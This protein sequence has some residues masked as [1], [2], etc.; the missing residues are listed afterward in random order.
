M[1]KGG[2]I[3]LCKLNLILAL[4]IISIGY[5]GDETTTAVDADSSNQYSDCNDSLCDSDHLDLCCTRIVCE[6]QGGYWYNE[7][8]YESPYTKIAA[9]NQFEHFRQA[10]DPQMNNLIPRTMTIGNHCLVE[11]EDWIY[12]IDSKGNQIFRPSGNYS[13]LEESMTTP[14][15]GDPQEWF[16]NSDNFHQNISKTVELFHQL[17]DVSDFLPPQAIVKNE[18]ILLCEMGN[19]N[20]NAYLGRSLIR[21][22]EPQGPLYFQTIF[23]GTSNPIRIDTNIWTN[24]IDELVNLLSDSLQQ[25]HPQIDNE[26]LSIGTFF[27]PDE[28]RFEITAYSYE[29]EEFMNM[30]ESSNPFD[31]DYFD[32][33]YPHLVDVALYRQS[34]D[35]HFWCWYWW[36]LYG[37]ENGVRGNWNEIEQNWQ[38]SAITIKF[39][40]N[41]R[42]YKLVAGE[43]TQ[44]ILP[45]DAS[46]VAASVWIGEK[47]FNVSDFRI[48]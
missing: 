27:D 15:A 30:E 8:C 32:L 39:H 23:D 3:N 1:L 33:S 35:Y 26:E 22:L 17:F 45:A 19:E 25:S 6:E 31:R 48:R 12:T 46:Y 43:P 16:N 24:N 10:I 21:L 41:L 20:V 34:G 40:R 14:F 2:W 4:T 38:H 37:R 9:E 5:G 47:N 29:G 13:H 18:V 42:D 36:E 11:T 7:G 44:T 28:Y